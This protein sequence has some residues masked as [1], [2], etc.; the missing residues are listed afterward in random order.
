MKTGRPSNAVACRNELRCLQ[1]WREGVR[2]QEIVCREL[3]LNKNTVSK[4]F[5]KFKTQ[6]LENQ[7]LDIFEEDIMAREEAISTLDK[8]LADLI[9]LRDKL[10]EEMDKF[11]KIAEKRLKAG[12]AKYKAQPYF[13]VNKYLEVIRMIESITVSKFKIKNE[14][15]ID[16]VMEQEIARKLEAMHGK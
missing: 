8:A 3:K 9:L 13:S 6:I 7:K 1:Y 10:K 12:D 14:P 5:T 15:T 16:Q 11:N 2:S 4:Y